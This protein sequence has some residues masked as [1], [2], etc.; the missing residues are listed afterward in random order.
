[1]VSSSCRK[2]EEFD[3]HPSILQTFLPVEMACCL[4]RRV[5]YTEIDSADGL[6]NY[7][8]AMTFTSQG[9]RS[10]CG[11]VFR[12]MD[13]IISNLLGFK[14]MFVQREANKVAHVCPKHSLF[15]S[16]GCTP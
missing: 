6:S 13:Q 15:Y 4:Q 3:D 5:R 11:Q 9:R 12:E 1:M 16:L 2:Y 14:F 10:V 8:Q 7:S